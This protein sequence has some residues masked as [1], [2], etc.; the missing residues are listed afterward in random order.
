MDVSYVK[1]W[2]ASADFLHMEASF[3]YLL[4]K[5][6]DKFKNIIKAEIFSFLLKYT[7]RE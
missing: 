6:K 5:N 2:A 7:Q 3:N 1:S 4:R